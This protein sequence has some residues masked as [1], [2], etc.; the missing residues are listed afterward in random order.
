MDLYHD[1]TNQGMLPKNFNNDMALHLIIIFK[2]EK[3]M[4][5][6]YEKVQFINFFLYIFIGL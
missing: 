3:K 2:S 5:K 4:L 6:L 1:I